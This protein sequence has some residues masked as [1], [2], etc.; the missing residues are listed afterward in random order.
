MDG[1]IIYAL[2]CL[3]NKR[4]AEDF[5]GKVFC[6][7]VYFFQRLVNRNRTNRHRRIADNPFAG[8]V[9][10]FSGRQIH[11]RVSA[12]STGP[13]GFFYLFFNGR[14]NCRVANISIDFHQEIPP[15]N[16]R[17]QFGVINVT[18]NYRTACSHL[19]PYKF[20]GNVIFWGIGTKAV[21]LVLVVHYLMLF[22]QLFV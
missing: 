22:A 3:L 19:C 15:N 1:K 21:T 12:P 7:S 17:F 16:H 6:F 2:L 13:N 5:P 18:W 20:G 14:S 9:D 11:N 10:I 4:I 8:F